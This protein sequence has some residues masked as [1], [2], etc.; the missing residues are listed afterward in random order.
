MRPLEARQFLAAQA[1]FSMR[2]RQTGTTSPLEMGT[3]GR[4]DNAPAI[5]WQ[6]MA[7]WA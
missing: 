3:T 1:D 4:I 6:G 2:Y 5:G 7:H